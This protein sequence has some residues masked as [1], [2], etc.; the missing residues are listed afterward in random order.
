MKRFIRIFVITALLLISTNLVIAQELFDKIDN[1]TAPVLNDELK[2]IRSRIPKTRVLMWYI[3]NAAATGT[4]VTARLDIPFK[5]EI[6][7]ATAYAK[8]APTGATTLKIDI[9]KNGTTIWG[10]QANRLQFVAGESTT[11][12]TSFTTTSAY[13]NDY[14]TVDIDDVG[15]TVAG[16]DLTV[17]LQIKEAR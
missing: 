13:E 1:N 15:S 9:N 7:K 3:P 8:T 10:N 2:D 16:S 11:S 17:Q 4:N 6:V 12:T 14:F 5:G